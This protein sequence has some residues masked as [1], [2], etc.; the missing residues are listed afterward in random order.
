[1]KCNKCHIISSR[2]GRFFGNRVLNAWN[3]LSRRT[4]TSPTVA[5]FKHSVAKLK[6]T[7]YFVHFLFLWQVLAQFHAIFV[8]CR[9][10]CP[11]LYASFRFFVAN[12]FD[13]I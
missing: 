11:V 1:M 12:K 2:D 9:H 5:R 10:S 13:L 3:S 8:S 6:L 7:L 4:I